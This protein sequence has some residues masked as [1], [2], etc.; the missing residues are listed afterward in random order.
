M[1]LVLDW[2]QF[3]VTQMLL[4][5]VSLSAKENRPA[6]YY[7]LISIKEIYTC[8]HRQNLALQDTMSVI[9]ITV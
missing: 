6:R 1:R 4:I 7:E 9:G 5:T 8:E 2:F 3:S